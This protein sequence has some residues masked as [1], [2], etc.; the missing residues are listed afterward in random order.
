V[1]RGERKSLP[2]LS[3][4]TELQLNAV[5]T[6]QL[7]AFIRLRLHPKGNISASAWWEHHAAGRVRGPGSFKEAQTRNP[8]NGEGV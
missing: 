2:S 8:D 1:R 3:E 7:Y 5:M 6:E 4:E